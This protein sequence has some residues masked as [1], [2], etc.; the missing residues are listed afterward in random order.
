MIPV[1][2]PAAGRCNALLVQATPLRTPRVP[3]GWTEFW[4][5]SRPGDRNELFIVYARNEP[6]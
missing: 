2:Y 1:E 4:R 5:G 6:S 3:P